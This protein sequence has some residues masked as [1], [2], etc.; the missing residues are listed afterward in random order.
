MVGKAGK[1]TL[2]NFQKTAELRTTDFPYFGDYKYTD[3]GPTKSYK[4]I[5]QCRI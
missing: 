1:Y 3:F 4:I 5:M 2:K